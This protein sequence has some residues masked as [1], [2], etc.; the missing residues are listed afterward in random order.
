MVCSRYI[1]LNP[2]R[3]GL[4]KR[5]SDYPRDEFCA[6][7]TTLFSPSESSG[8]RAYCLLSWHREDDFQTRYCL[9]LRAEVSRIIN[10]STKILDYSEFT[11]VGRFGIIVLKE[12]MRPRRILRQEC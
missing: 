11:V 12:S 6:H 1:E 9:D 4:V 10:P 8:V 3:A 7:N 5:P 2:V